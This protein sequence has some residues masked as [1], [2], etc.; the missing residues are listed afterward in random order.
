MT[1]SSKSNVTFESDNVMP[2]DE[3]KLGSRKMFAPHVYTKLLE[4]HHSSSVSWQP[5]T[6]TILS[7]LLTVPSDQDQSELTTG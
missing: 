2:L 4:N 3:A 7:S 1:A 6:A 5:W